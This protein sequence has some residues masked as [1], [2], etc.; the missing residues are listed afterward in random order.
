[1]RPCSS[2]IASERIGLYFRCLAG[3]IRGQPADSVLRLREEGT[4]RPFRGEAAASAARDSCWKSPPLLYS[5]SA[6]SRAGGLLPWPDGQPPAVPG[7]DSL[8][9]GGGPRRGG[10][11]YGRRSSRRPEDWPPSALSCCTGCRRA[12]CR[13]DRNRGRGAPVPSP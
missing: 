10:L 6:T 3:V 9:G 12:P 4:V 5:R 13:R 2:D 8:P 7:G 11:R 1:M